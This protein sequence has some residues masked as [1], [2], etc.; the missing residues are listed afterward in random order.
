MAQFWRSPRWLLLLLASVCGQ[1]L[2]AAAAP[3]RPG[4]PNVTLRHIT[5]DIDHF[6]FEAV[7]GQFQQRYFVYDGFVPTGKPA[8]VVW[9]YCGNEDN[10]ELYVVKQ[11]VGSLAGE[12]APAAL[13]S[14]GRSCVG[15]VQV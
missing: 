6:G 12:E 7:T 8:S 13:H 1:G 3:A 14:R 9:F 2:G 5:Q 4:L 11:K 10:V 15:V